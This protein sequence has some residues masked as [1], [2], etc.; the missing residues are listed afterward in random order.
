MKHYLAAAALLGVSL[1]SGTAA[2]QYAV[3]DESPA[4]QWN[5][6]LHLYGMGAAIDGD[7]QV[8]P[9]GVPVSISISDLFDALRMGGMAAYRVDNGNWSF[10][11]DATYMDLAW[12]ASTNGGRAG[13]RMQVD[14]ITLMVTAGKRIGPHTELLGSLAYFDVSSDLRLSVLQQSRTASSG[15][16]WVDPLVGLQHTFPLS[17]SWSLSLRGDVGGFGVNSSFTWQAWAVVRNQVSDRFGWF[18]GYRAL[19]YDYQTGSGLGF[20]RYNLTQQGPGLG[21][22]FSF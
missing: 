6:T 18:V 3:D 20:Q 5:Q 8:G 21:V 14:Q 19:G 22:S 7:A 10:S 9:V 15:T 4:G 17:D 13:A 11:A 1:F 16:D 12:N 2:A